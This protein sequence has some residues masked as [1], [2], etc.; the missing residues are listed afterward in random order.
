M[1]YANVKFDF[2]KKKKEKNYTY[3][4]TFH[5][6]GWLSLTQVRIVATKG[7]CLTPGAAA[8]MELLGKA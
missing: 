6:Q 7:Q 8:N 3:Y 5:Q 4:H 2:R 1:V